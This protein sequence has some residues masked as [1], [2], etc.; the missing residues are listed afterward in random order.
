MMISEKIKKLRKLKD[1]SQSEVANI[2][3]IS[4][5]A[6][7]KIESGFTKS[8]TI[9]IGKGIAKA[10]DVSFNEL[11]DIDAPSA[12]IDQTEKL[13]V[14]IEAL[15]KQLD[16]KML[17]I[18]LLLRE[19][20]IYKQT[21]IEAIVRYSDDML[22]KINEEISK[23][24][25]DDDRKFLEFDR[26]RVLNN[27]QY[28]INNFI[29]I[30]FFNQSDIDNYYKKLK[31]HYEALSS[32]WKDNFKTGDYQYTFDEKTGDLIS[33]EEYLKRKDSEN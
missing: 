33:K 24:T 25:N 12:S 9:E 5:A 19:K 21:S 27:K 32:V 31:Q 13:I 20:E 23:A 15:K 8:I 18:D 10:L 11:F 4:Q 26:K 30:G 22:I 29:H 3:N 6:Y 16:E 1:L 17:L 7:A 2:I 14:E 28:M